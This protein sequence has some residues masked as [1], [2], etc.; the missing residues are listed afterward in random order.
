MWFKSKICVSCLELKSMIAQ[1]VIAKHRERARMLRIDHSYWTDGSPNQSNK[2]M[3][4]V[5]GVPEIRQLHEIFRRAL[6][7]AGGGDSSP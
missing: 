4:F 1:L 6:I 5:P 2:F 3:V 7:L